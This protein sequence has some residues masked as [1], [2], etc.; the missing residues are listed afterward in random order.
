VTQPGEPIEGATRLI[1]VRHAETEWNASGR[2]QGHRDVALSPRGREQ[3]RALAD[4]LV[5]EAP[6]RIVSSDLER[7]RETARP[8]AE[9]TGAPLILDPDLREQRFGAWEGLSFAEVERREPDEAARFRR[10]E[11]HF[12]PPGGESREEVRDRVLAAL[13]RHVPPSEGGS[14]SV[15]VAHG[16]VLQVI[17]YAVLGVPPEAPRRFAVSNAAVS[18]LERAGA[19]PWFLTKWND[20]A[21]LVGPVVR[22]PLE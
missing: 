4:R 3:A 16:G 14:A 8:V 19:G 13:D 7:A 1:L 12:R 15:V 2:L 21:H 9:A 11:A 20:T 6:V 5:A 18:L 22:F 10:R 17:L